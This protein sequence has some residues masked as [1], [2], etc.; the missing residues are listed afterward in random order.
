MQKG[1]SKPVTNQCNCIWQRCKVNVPNHGREKLDSRIEVFR[2]ISWN[3]KS[4]TRNLIFKNWRKPMNLEQFETTKISFVFLLH[5][6]PVATQRARDWLW[7]ECSGFNVNLMKWFIF[8][9]SFVH[10]L[11]S[12]LFRLLSDVLELTQRLCSGIQP[13]LVDA[14]AGTCAGLA[15]WLS[16]SPQSLVQI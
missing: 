7:L 11:A 6:S 8:R 13:A 12:C 15:H 10:W 3:D 4:P 16:L 14:P 1:L 5:L 9:K 2:G